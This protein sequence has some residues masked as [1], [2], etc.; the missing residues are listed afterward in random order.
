MSEAFPNPPALVIAGPTASGKTEVALALA[1]RLPAE[2]VSAD[3]RQIY[4][5]MDIGTAKPTPAQR[6]QVPHHF[7]DIRNPDEWYT[8]G[9]YGRA[10]RRVV[11]EIMQRGKTPL[12]VGGSGFYLQALLQGLSTALP[13]DLRL[14]AQLQQRLRDEGAPALHR[15]L[16]RIDP[17]AAARLHPNDGHRLV[18]ALEV[19]QLSGCTLTELQRQAGE[20]PSFRYRFFCLALERSR[21]YQRIN[22]RVE[23]MVA[24]GLLEE[25]RRLLALGYSPQLNALQ[26]VGYQEAFQFLNGEISHAE[27]VALIQRHTRQY[28][29]RQLTWFRRRPNC[30][31]LTLQEQALPETAVELILRAITDHAG[32]GGSKTG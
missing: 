7:I 25:C 12:I 30:E 2:I 5:G 21:L 31:W 13:S 32:R 8:A 27:M 1:R 24:A 16:A 20:P 14:R 19:Y 23:E 29:K 11:V 9:E 28:A 15:E 4:R 22:R 26:T 17:P 10:A 3:S 6:R 18:R